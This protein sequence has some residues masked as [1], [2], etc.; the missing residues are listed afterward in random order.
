MAT[1]PGGLGPCCLCGSSVAVG[2][3]RWDLAQVELSSGRKQTPR[4]SES[5]T[6]G[7]GIG[8]NL[9]GLFLANSSPP[10]LLKRP[11][12][13]VWARPPKMQ[14]AKVGVGTWAWSVRA[15]VAPESVMV[16]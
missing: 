16:S 10:H 2:C 14:A 7:E 1:A 12:S 9:V 3:D 5:E 4:G 15:R 11:S 13:A 8:P 6:E